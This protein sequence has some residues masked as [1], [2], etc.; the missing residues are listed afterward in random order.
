MFFF[1]DKSSSYLNIFVFFIII[2]LIFFI[3][4]S[5]YFSYKKIILVFYLSIFFTALNKK[6]KYLILINLIIFTFFL[7]ILFLFVDKSN[8]FT[9]AIYEKHFL[10]GVNNLSYTSKIYG[11]GLRNF[12]NNGE[13]EIKK[14]KFISDKFGF[15]NQ[16]SP[17][18]SEYIIVGD[19]FMH[20]LRI[21]NENLLNEILNN[22]N[23]LKYYNASLTSQ[24]VAHYLETIKFFK[25]KNPQKKFIMFI[26]AGNDFLEYKKIKKNYSNKIDNNLLRFYFNIKKKFDF[27]SKISFILKTIKSNNLNNKVDEIK[28]KGKSFYFYKDYYVK[29]DQILNFS[30]EFEIYDKYLPNYIFIIPSKA[31][32]YCKYLKN[33]KCDKNN[34]ENIV[35]N[36]FLFKNIIIFDS[37]DYLRQQASSMLE[38]EM[39]LYD[40]DDTHLNE[41]G[42]S[43]L[44]K[45]VIRKIYE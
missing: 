30:K 21:S 36:N 14:I 9:K 25:E 6:I 34:Y 8:I 1:K 37:T 23:E 43:L 27:H 22:Y 20:N 35:R 7:K 29:E 33:Y 40:T 42:L 44:S 31:Q 32:V 10:Y 12:F 2:P 18:D 17:E 39:I 28:I 24:D 45:F 5:F 19:S 38:N 11:G 3:I 16:I 13:L 41:E 26:F 4:T 15:R